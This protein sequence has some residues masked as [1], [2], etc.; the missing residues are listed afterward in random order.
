MLQDFEFEQI[1]GSETFHVDTRVILATNEDLAHRV[2]E[3]TFRQDLF[4][5]INVIN[6]EL[7]SLRER[8][9]DIPLLAS[10]FLQQVCQESGR[11]VRGFSDEALELLQHYHY[12]GNVRELQNIM[13]RAV[14]LGKSDMICPE[15]LPP[16]LHSLP[17]YPVAEPVGNRSLKEALEGPERQI[18][19]EVLQSKN[20]N[21]N[22]TADALGIN[23]TTLYKK[24]KK[25]GL[26]EARYAAPRLV[27]S[28]ESFAASGS[29][30]S[31]C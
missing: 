18:I 5:R 30:L 24:M 8:M 14:L 23:R 27:S 7:P 12:P 9:S 16:A 26:E 19:L 28:S 20:W 15:D 10:H 21:R 22:E 25:L 1:G 29:P 31:A 13:E 4:Y 6:L 2:A 17:G 11:Q 3:G